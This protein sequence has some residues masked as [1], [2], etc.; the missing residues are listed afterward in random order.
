V[1]L[2]KEKR[3]PLQVSGRQANNPARKG[4]ATMFD[5]M[6]H[7]KRFGKEIASFK[8]EMDNLFN[9]FFDMEFP[10]ATRLF[11]E[12]NWAPR[13]DISEDKG[14]ITVKAEIPGCEAEDIDVD[15]ASILDFSKMTSSPPIMA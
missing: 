7:G 2:E 10:V 8:N 5:L 4:E 9:L 1:C 13:V 11:G 14:D 6:P 15:V 3:D 12:G